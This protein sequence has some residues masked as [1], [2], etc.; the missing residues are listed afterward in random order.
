MAHLRKIL[1]VVYLFP[2]IS[3]VGAIRFA[4]FAK[5]LPE[6]G[7]EPVIYT[8]DPSRYEDHRFEEGS[9]EDDP[10]LIYR[11]RPVPGPLEIYSRLF[12][13]VNHR[14]ADQPEFAAQGAGQEES[15]SLKRIVSSLLRIPDDKP[16]WMASVVKNGYRIMKKHGIDVF[17][18]SGPPMGTHMAG[19]LLKAATGAKWFADFR[20]PWW[21]TCRRL[22]PEFRSTLSDALT[23]RM[24]SFVVRRADVVISTAPSLT[25]YF[26]SLLNSEQGSKCITITNGFDEDDFTGIHGETSSARASGIRICHAG[27]LYA[28]RNPEPFFA[29]LRALLLRGALDKKS[30][31]VEFIGDCSDYNGTSMAELVQ[32]YSL[33]S[34]VNFTGLM[35]HRDCL[36]R[37]TNAD[38]LLLFAQDFAEQIP[39][40]IFE[41]LRIDKPIF[42]LVTDGDAGRV[43]KSSPRAF[44][45]DPHTAGQVEERL[46]QMLRF[47]SK[48][49]LSDERET[50]FRQY[51]RRILTQRLAEYLDYYRPVH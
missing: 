40:K 3:A 30:I 28:G 39:A 14:S 9:G 4:K 44:L 45:A 13:R 31:D 51:D 5:F 19:A 20:D 22:A 27:S 38:G 37:L 33:E 49:D 35:P 34:V 11:A 25:D 12:P 21:G 42:A 43:L 2:P 7:W 46:L 16:G 41:Y 8:V 24:E 47:I 18:T 29:A 6:F 10:H 32:K 26:R 48:P 36:E 15:R 23:K 1:I 17:M 50:N